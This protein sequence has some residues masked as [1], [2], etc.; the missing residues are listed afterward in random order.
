MQAPDDRSGPTLSRSVRVAMTS[1]LVVGLSFD[2]G[3]S[4]EIDAR[5]PDAMSDENEGTSVTVSLTEVPKER[6][7]A[8]ATKR[9][10]F[11]HR[12]VGNNILEGVREVLADT[13]EIELQ[14]VEARRE[15]PHLEQ[16]GLGHMLIGKNGDPG[17]KIRDFEALM[18]EGVG[19]FA[20]L[21]FFKFC[22]VD[23][24]HES[25]VDEVFAS[26][27]ETMDRLVS[28]Y[29][30]T[31]FVHASVPLRSR[32]IE[33]LKQLKDWVKVVLGKGGSMEGNR[34]R[35]EF[36]ARLRTAYPA[37]EVFDIA[38]IESTLP[39]G[40]RLAVGKSDD[41]VYTMAPEYTSDGGHLS[42]VGR[43]RVAEQ[44]LVFLALSV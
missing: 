38:L 7:E 34:R 12:S 2:L 1:L 17:S 37:A 5:G 31:K 44:L 4:N 32:P 3:C 21:A 41:P 30:D 24:N 33:P 10:F 27:R 36:N 20:D 16:P 26:Y 39:D 23:F 25:D 6:W 29:P 13:P 9:I 40:S 28:T 22:Y 18:T 43:R 19:S 15:D 8:L 14:I 35:N 42:P 11:G